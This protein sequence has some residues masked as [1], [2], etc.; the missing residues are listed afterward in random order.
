[1][2]PYCLFSSNRR[3]TCKEVRL[4]PS[5]VSKTGH[6]RPLRP[7][8]QE[9]SS[10]GNTPTEGCTPPRGAARSRPPSGAGA[11][12]KVCARRRVLGLCG[13]T[14]TKGALREPRRAETGASLPSRGDRQ[15][16]ESPDT[17]TGH[18][19]RQERP[20]PQTSAATSHVSAGETEDKG[21]G[22]G[23][24]E[25]PMNQGGHVLLPRLNPV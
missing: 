16:Q 22:L 10:D 5:H 1:M 18:Q 3:P 2:G 25:P 7:E 11:S 8:L 4:D 9:R 13:H 12:S 17:E 20:R 24:A 19:R 23:G 6:G 21:A 14:G 15:T